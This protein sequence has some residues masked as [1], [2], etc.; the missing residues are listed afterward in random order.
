M[1]QKIK[2]Q[3]FSLIELLIAIAFIGVIITLIM[4]MNSFNA[5][6]WRLNENKTKAYF[7]A[8]ESLEA[9]KLL[10]WSELADGDYHLVLQDEAWSLVEG[11]E[12]LEE[13]Y[14]RTINISSVNREFI[15]NGHVYGEI[16]ENGNIDPDSKKITAQVTWLGKNAQTQ[17][18]LLENYLSRWQAKRF[19]QTD[20]SGGS[21]QSDWTEEN[22]FFNKN[23]AMSTAVEGIG[24]LVSGFLDWNQ[25]VPTSTF[26]LLNS[27]ADVNDV[28]EYGDYVFIVTSNNSAGSEF[29]IVNISDKK[30]PSLVSSLN[31]G[32]AASSIVVQDDYAY[33]GTSWD[34][35]EI[36]V[37]DISNLNIPVIEVNINLDGTQNVLSLD[38]SATQLYV[39]QGNYLRS[40]DISNPSAPT[41]LDSIDLN[42]TARNVFVS[43]DNVYV[44]TQNSSQ[45]LQ[46]IDA[47][48]PANLANIGNFNLSGS[49]IAT[50]VFV[51]GNRAYVSTD[52]NSGSEF[53]VLDISSTNAPVLLGSYNT[54]AR[55]YAFKIVGPYAILAL[56]N[57]SKEI[58]ILDISFP[59]TINSIKSFD[60]S[61]LVYGLSA[62]CAFIYAGS[63]S[64]TQELIVISTQV[65]E[66]GYENNGQ[67]ESS[68]FDTGSSQV[69]YNWIAWSGSQPN[70]T[71]IR[72]QIATSNNA[73]GPWNFVG[74]SG[75]SSDYYTTAAKEFINH[76]HHLDQRYLR[77]KL[78]LSSADEL[79]I[80]ILEEV[81]ISYSNH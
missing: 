67:L 19:V 71:T 13:K 52:T 79:Q 75:N 64:N 80:P 29:F 76:S 22:K 10:N 33:V 34:D 6:L 59:A 53:F 55:V 17:E 68:T 2:N 41:V 4:T 15:D 7:Y 45:E 62:N 37:I 31:I 44:A 39:A 57:S 14:T 40:I 24:T 3:G 5:D 47:S 73:N 21:G 50:D 26:D 74:P 16:V 63:T 12:I 1:P 58:E 77:Y 81:K 32:A 66:C 36:R 20:W 9:I 78:F 49:L 54:G 35:K 42:A 60:L 28:Y 23:I 27:S 61:A 43:A 72:F 38:I 30:N 56:N 48:N 46:I 65:A 51:L 18:I 70:D 11:A 8:S 25:A 69:S